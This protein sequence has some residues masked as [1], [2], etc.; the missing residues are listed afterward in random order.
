MV[1]VRWKKNF[2]YIKKQKTKNNVTMKK[3]IPGLHWARETT[4]LHNGWV[5]AI[6][7]P[8][9]EREREYCS[10]RK[11][12]FKLKRQQCARIMHVIMI[13]FNDQPSSSSNGIQLET[14]CANHMVFSLYS[15]IERE[16][17][18]ETEK[19]QNRH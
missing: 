14:Y 10:V 13:L 1:R 9:L 8:L 11:K 12:I 6:Q 19:K 3:N 15:L 17:K 18:R 5:S 16:R 7:S 4:R 2:S